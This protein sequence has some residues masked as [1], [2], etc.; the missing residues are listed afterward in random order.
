MLVVVYGI[1]RP[2]V[3][4]R[5]DAWCD[6]VLQSSHEVHPSVRARVV[7]GQYTRIN[8]NVYFFHHQYVIEN[9]KVRV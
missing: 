9:C 7:L 5:F 2:V 6:T 3:C 1:K 4:Q 8:S